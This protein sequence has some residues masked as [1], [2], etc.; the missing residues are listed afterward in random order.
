MYHLINDLAFY[1]WNQGLEHDS[2]TKRGIFDYRR[3]VEEVWIR[4]VVEG[5]TRFGRPAT[6]CCGYTEESESSG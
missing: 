3:M 6:E 4:P 2:S 1:Q 5:D